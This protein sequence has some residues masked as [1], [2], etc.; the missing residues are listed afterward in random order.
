MCAPIRLSAF[1]LELFKFLLNEQHSSSEKIYFVYRVITW[2]TQLSS[3][4]PKSHTFVPS[5]HVEQKDVFKL[6]Q[7]PRNTDSSPSLLRTTKLLL[8]SALE[9]GMKEERCTE[10]GIL[11]LLL[12]LRDTKTLL[13]REVFP[14]HSRHL[15]QFRSPKFVS[16]AVV[17]SELSKR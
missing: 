9:I 16:Q 10:S 2:P 3:P 1:S 8:T 12:I 11:D 15:D 4:Y 6:A 5:C 13:G 14:A 17:F 7:F